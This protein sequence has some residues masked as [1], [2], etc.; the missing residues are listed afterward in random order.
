MPMMKNVGQTADT[1]R[2]GTARERIIST[3][4]DI[5]INALFA[6]LLTRAALNAWRTTEFWRLSNEF[7]SGADEDLAASL[8]H[9]SFALPFLEE[10]ARGEGADVR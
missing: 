3:E 4:L 5:R 7:F 6:R 8:L 2:A 10:A 9:G 1:I